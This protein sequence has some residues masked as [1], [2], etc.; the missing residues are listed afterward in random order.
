MSKDKQIEEMAK[1][2]EY[3][4]EYS[5]YHDY[6]DDYTEVEFDYR[7]TAENIAKKG[8]RKVSD[9]ITEI[10]E[11]LDD[12]D[13]QLNRGDLDIKYFGSAVAE[14]KKKYAEVL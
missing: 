13:I 6:I 14:L 11:D 10:F 9:I 7:K 8:Y 2:L 12:L 1:D 3:E 4:I 5:V